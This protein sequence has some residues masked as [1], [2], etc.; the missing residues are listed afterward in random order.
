MHKNSGERR[1]GMDLETRQGE[2]G[3][4]LA[5]SRFS[6]NLARNRTLHATFALR[7]LHPPD[8]WY[9]PTSRSCVCEMALYNR[10]YLSRRACALLNRC[11]EDAGERRTSASCISLTRGLVG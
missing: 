1:L 10:K 6:I 4:T 11:R 2:S 5:H 7:D 9:A 3:K 8:S